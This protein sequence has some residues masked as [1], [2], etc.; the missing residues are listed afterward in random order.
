[1]EE[2]HIR[3]KKYDILRCG[4]S[5]VLGKS[6]PRLECDQGL[7]YAVNPWLFRI[8]GFYNDDL[9]IVFHCFNIFPA[10]IITNRGIEASFGIQDAIISPKINA[11]VEPIIES[12]IDL[13][14]EFDWYSC[15]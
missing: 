10:Q 8:T 13:L 15:E 5:H 14:L 7:V 2:E 11:M 3:R 1:M 9:L 6:T 4:V 12:K